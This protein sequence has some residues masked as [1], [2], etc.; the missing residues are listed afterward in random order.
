[1]ARDTDYRVDAAEIL[2]WLAGQTPA[3]RMLQ[4]LYGL[5]LTEWLDLP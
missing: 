1:V 2:G 4:G 5:A 3:H